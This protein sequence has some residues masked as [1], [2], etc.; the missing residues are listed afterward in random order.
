MT[1][2]T[3]KIISLS[4]I[5]IVAF[6]GLQVLVYILDLNQ[7]GTYLT[8]AFWIYL[9]LVVKMVVLFDLHF[10]NPGSWERAKKKHEALTHYSYR[11]SRVLLSALW[12]R[13][14]H[15]R[16]WRYLRS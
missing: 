12:D 6:G 16:R 8:T 15:F 3:Q 4:L 2:K 1:Y 14:E 5:S 9:Y 10:K 7:V 11:Y 13:L